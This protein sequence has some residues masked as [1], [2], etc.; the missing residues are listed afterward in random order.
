VTD[1]SIIPGIVNDEQKA[2]DSN[3]KESKDPEKQFFFS[4]SGINDDCTQAVKSVK[5]NRDDEQRV[6]Q[7]IRVKDKSPVRLLLFGHQKERSQQF[8]TEEDN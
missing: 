1:H 2:C 5:D 6:N 8:E 4:N 3:A 7:R